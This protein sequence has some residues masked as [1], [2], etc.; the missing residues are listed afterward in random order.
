MAD[1]NIRYEMADRSKGINCAGIGAIHLIFDPDRKSDEMI[2]G[3]S[4]VRAT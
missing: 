2:G 1:G 4:R 3:V